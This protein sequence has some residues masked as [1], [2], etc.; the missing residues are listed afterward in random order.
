MSLKDQIVGKDVIIILE[1]LLVL[2]YWAAYDGAQYISD[3]LGGLER[4]TAEQYRI[5][6]SSTETEFPVIDADTVTTSTDHA[7]TIY[8][9]S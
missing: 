7:P 4:Q 8:L 9:S 6:T 2:L 5:H 3:A 1:I